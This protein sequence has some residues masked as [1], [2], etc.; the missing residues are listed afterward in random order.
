MF[1]RLIRPLVICV[2]FLCAP[3][4]AT[5][6]PAGDE[7]ADGL[8]RIWTLRA[9]DIGLLISEAAELKSHADQ[10]AVPLAQDVRDAR[11]RFGRLSGL[12]QA[13]RG[14]P[15]EQ[16][17][18]VEQMRNSVK[19]L[20]ADIAPLESTAAAVQTRLEEISTLEKDLGGGAAVDP[21]GDADLAAYRKA[22]REGRQRLAPLAAQLEK[23]LAPARHTMRTF[24]AEI[25]EIESG[26]A[27]VWEGYYLTPSDNS[28]EALASTPSLLGDWLSTLNARLAFAYPQNREEW[29]G[30][31]KSFVLS[32]A[33]MAAIGFLAFRGAQNLPG[34]WQQALED[35]VRRSWVFVGLGFSIL[36]ASANSNGGIYMAFVLAGTL[37]VIA[38]VAALSWRLR[39][40]AR[41]GLAGKPSPLGRL[42][43]PAAAGVIMLFSDLPLRVLGI[44]WGLAMA[45]FLVMILSLNRR[46]KSEGDLPLLERMAYGCA[47]WFGLASLL[48]TVFGY[49]RL[50]ILVFMLLFALVNTVILASGLMAL[51]DTLAD[52][53]SSRQTQPVG[54]AVL[55][56]LS[57]P[58]A[59]LLSLLCT[60]PWVWAVPGARYLAEYLMSANY[61]LGE[62]SFDF[63]RL[64]LIVLLFFLFRS[65]ISLGRASL[66]QLPE[67]LPTLERGV[68]PP[69][70]SLVTYGLWSLF[71]LVALG[72]L[73][74]NFTSL[75]VVAGGLSV[76]IGFGL[77]NIFNNLVSGL[78]LIFGRSVLVGDYIEVGGAQGTVKEISIRST[79]IETPDRARVYVPN[80]TIMAGQFTNWT[81]GSRVVRRAISIGVAYGSDIDQVRALLLEAAGAEDHVL[82]LPAAYVT[83][84]NFAASSLDFTLFVFIDDFNNATA[85]V[86]S[87][88]FRVEK[89]F[90]AR[91][92]DIPF[93]QMTL[94]MPP[95]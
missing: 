33:L 72:I 42:Y 65:L 38:G 58:L 31:G 56:A 17:T 14:H 32:A 88:R 66:K 35:V 71:G 11:V 81:R 18:L 55:K 23:I 77:Q 13:S 39:L 25:Q 95:G 94:H 5:A 78:M 51:S 87:L 79:V 75:A 83:F 80:S 24:E 34:L 48:I 43:L 61:T 68:I 28:L 45:V 10:L 69:L 92:I 52:R 7:G 57:I 64:A 73:G 3:L 15:T 1:E 49:A 85:A 90:A 89:L 93:P 36:S 2:L 44:V 6:A 70:K 8:G 46:H 63:S 9:E 84:D 22:L 74:V 21:A 60:L 50:A 67:R 91:G 19:K 54:N 47:F 16:L 86:S 29:G 4:S 62:A 53:F 12:Y 26:L 40:V 27:A 20:K 59:W 82:Q 30:S 37:I 41:P 76:G